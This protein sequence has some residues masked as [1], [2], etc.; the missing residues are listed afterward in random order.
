MHGIIDKLR[1]LIL[2]FTSRMTEPVPYKKKS[3]EKYVESEH[4]MMDVIQKIGISCD[5]I[6]CLK[7][8][9]STLYEERLASDV[10]GQNQSIKANGIQVFKRSAGLFLCNQ[11]MKNHPHL[12]ITFK[13]FDI[14]KFKELDR[15]VEGYNLADLKLNQL[16]TKLNANILEENN[17]NQNNILFY[18]RYGG[19]EFVVV[20]VSKKG[21][22]K[23]D[24][25]LQTD[26][27]IRNVFFELSLKIKNNKI[28]NIL[29]PKEP[30]KREIFSYFLQH[31]LLL[32]QD[33]IQK[34]EDSGETLEKGLLKPIENMRVSPNTSLI[35]TIKESHIAKH[36]TE[37]SQHLIEYYNQ[38]MLKPHLKEYILS[39]QEFQNIC[40]IQPIKS[41]ITIDSKLLK[42]I[43]DKHNHLE[44]DK[45]MNQTLQQIL[46]CIDER[47]LNS[48]IFIGGEGSV[49]EIAIHERVVGKY[50]DQH[51]DLKEFLVKTRHEKIINGHTFSMPLGVSMQLGKSTRDWYR[52]VIGSSMAPKDR[53]IR[54]RLIKHV[55]N[56]GFEIANQN[57]YKNAIS[58]YREL[59]IIAEFKLYL[60]K[61]KQGI[62]NAN[63]SST[64]DM[65]MQF[66]LGDNLHY[67]NYL[68]DR[69]IVRLNILLDYANTHSMTSLAE[70]TEQILSTHTNKI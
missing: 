52:E 22:T 17:Q 28:E 60:L 67:S 53:K 42:E 41:I 70:Y 8:M 24:E 57:W 54:N 62:S 10:I 59:D 43:N 25:D 44:G 3:V 34:I 15:I 2:Q 14:E 4:P 21:S 9:R 29:A 20:L 50:L 31:N 18:F 1:L 69:Y 55:R 13:L 27:L 32:N 51:S 40:V 46:I 61:Q 7:L 36:N 19:D 35:Y 49:T 66:F 16:C 63:Y 48:S 45:Y 56:Q 11:I 68:S 30:N 26:N 23:N 33:D 6:R 47:D 5:L 12:M 65:L 39:P 58:S 64:L 37:V 38:V